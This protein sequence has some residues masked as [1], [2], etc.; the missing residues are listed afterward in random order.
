MRFTLD[1]NEIPPSLPEEVIL[2]AGVIGSPHIL[3]LSGI[4][5]D[6][7]KSIDGKIYSFLKGVGKNLQDH[8][9]IRLVYQCPSNIPTLNT[10]LKYP[11]H[12]LRVG[13]EYALYQSGPLSMAAS[14]VAAFVNSRKFV[15]S[16]KLCQVSQ[17]TNS[18]ID[19]DLSR[20]IPEEELD[21]VSRARRFGSSPDIQ[22]HLQ[23]LSS[24]IHSPGKGFDPM[25]AF[26][27]SVCQLRP[28]STGWIEV[29]SNNPQDKP[30]IHANYITTKVRKLRL[31]CI[32]T[33]SI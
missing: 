31:C 27:A 15:F 2:S 7:T 30:K 1:C 19:I 23:P 33:M 5:F 22:Y 12:Y 14:S 28:T 32:D 6:E 4:G 9:Q 13:I 16:E 24:A 20:K 8:L 17:K 29:V 10:T 21:G 26:T 25:S 3:Q 11:W 18:H